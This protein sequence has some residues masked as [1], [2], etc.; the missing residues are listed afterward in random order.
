M[1]NSSTLLAALSKM[2]GT[3]EDVMTILGTRIELAKQEGLQPSY[4]ADLETALKAVQSTKT[5]EDAQASIQTS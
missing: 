2:A 5:L 4:L 1:A 3:R